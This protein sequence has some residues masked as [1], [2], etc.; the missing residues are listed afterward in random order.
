MSNTGDDFRDH[1]AALLNTRYEDV[2]TEIQLTGKKADIRF[3]IQIGHQR[4][5][6]AA[7]CKK[8]NRGLSRDDVRDIIHDYDAACQNREV[9][10]IWIVCD[11]T[12]A[13]GA[14]DYV[15]AYRHCQIMTGTECE[16]AI[17]DFRPLLKFLIDDFAA[18][19][20]AKYYIPPT[21]EQP[22]GRI[23]LHSHVTGWLNGER[24]SPIAIWAGY[25][26]GKTT[27]ARYL[28]YTL[29]MKCQGDYGSRI[30]ILLSLG[31]F[32]TAPNLET[33]IVTQLTNHYGVRYLSTTASEFST[34]AI[35]SCSFSMASMR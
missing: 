16:Q 28:A 19:R 12:P 1:I 27:Y 15:G 8:W 11:R 5:Q 2:R 35:G 24:P 13:A 23:D 18:D 22:S 20:V 31:E 14:R 26:M 3:D 30:P 25:G 10:Q 17:V 34:R 32:T 6:V 21:F 9:D 7:E 4:I 29:A 33:L